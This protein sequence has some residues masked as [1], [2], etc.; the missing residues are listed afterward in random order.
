VAHLLRLGG[1]CVNVGCIPKKIMHYAG[2]LGHRLRETN[3]LGWALGEHAD[4]GKSH[5]WRTLVRNVG[6]YIK[7]L[8]FNYKVGGGGREEKHG[9][10]RA[11]SSTRGRA[12]S[13]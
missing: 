7:G 8:N 4:E 5:D 1:T 10:G 6:D 13:G 11:I 9:K 2:L 12:A 3:A